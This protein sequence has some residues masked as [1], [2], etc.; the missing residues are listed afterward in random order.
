MAQVVMPPGSGRTCR[1]GVH[2]M[3]VHHVHQPR[4]ALQAL[5]M[6]CSAPLG[7]LVCNQLRAL[8]LRTKVCSQHS[9]CC[10]HLQ[11]ARITHSQPRLLCSSHKAPEPLAHLLLTPRQPP[12]CE[13][14]LCVEH[15]QALVDGGDAGDEA[16]LAL[17]Q[18]Q[19]SGIVAL[20]GGCHPGGVG[21]PL[22][23]GLG[24]GQA[25][26]LWRERQER[27]MGVGGQGEQLR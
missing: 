17:P 15:R 5:P 19:H 2:H 12:T 4:Q 23:Q 21:A 1:Q 9:C 14:Q 20:L 24:R 13:P 25:L 8:H 22:L 16:P 11:Q 27:G 10:H 7:I 26:V 18:R 6:S 3:T